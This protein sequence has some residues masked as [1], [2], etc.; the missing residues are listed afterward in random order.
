MSQQTIIIRKKGGGEKITKV[1]VVA[2]PETIPIIERI[3]KKCR[4]DWK[5]EQ[6]HELYLL[7]NT[8]EERDLMWIQRIRKKVPK[9]GNVYAVYMF[10]NVKNRKVYVGQ[11]KNLYARLKKHLSRSS[12]EEGQWD[13]QRAIRKYGMHN[14]R[15]VILLTDKDDMELKNVKER[16]K[17]EALYV[18]KFNSHYEGYNTLPCTTD[19]RERRYI[20]ENRNQ[21]LRSLSYSN[22]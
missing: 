1:E 21:F 15:F 19:E 3:P 11:T 9:K 18:K 13:L 20:E 6:M 8:Y 10:M 4:K 7:E 16:L 2:E 22:L 5:E 12:L 14:F 17:M